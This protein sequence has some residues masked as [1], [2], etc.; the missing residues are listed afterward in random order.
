MNHEDAVRILSE[1]NQSH[2]LKFWNRLSEKQRTGLLA[3]I[4]E[5]DFDTI[6]KMSALL[7]NQ[8]DTSTHVTAPMEPAH[9]T[10][11]DGEA[12][13]AA[14]RIG[15]FE[16]RNGHVAA[17]IVA[18]GQG[19]RLGYDGPKGCYPSVRLPMPRSFIFIHERYSPS[20][21]SGKVKSPSIS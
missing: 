14:E 11:L 10:V 2:I 8:T 13:H 15:A 12:R 1:N 3:Q 4:A 5:L 17:L 20:L 7:T 18:G 19:S 16:I 9:V 6:A 21:A